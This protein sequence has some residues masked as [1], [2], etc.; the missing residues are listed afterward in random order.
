MV[1]SIL[2]WILGWPAWRW[3]LA[4]AVPLAFGARPYTVLTGSME[5]TISPG[6]VVIDE[7]ISPLEARVGDVVTFRDPED[8]SGRSPTG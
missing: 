8:Q 3:L 7:R 1:T 4:I 5:P 2:A 6:D